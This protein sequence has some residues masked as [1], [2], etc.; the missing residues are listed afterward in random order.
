MDVGVNEAVDIK[1]SA[2]W[3]D[4]GG[5]IGSTRQG[6]PESK[7]GLRE[8]STLLERSLLR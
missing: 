6:S 7:N 3:W 8:D 1:L 5:Q 4:G 2:S